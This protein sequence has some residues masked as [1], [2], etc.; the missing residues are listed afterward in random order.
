MKRQISRI[1]IRQ[2]AKVIGAVYAV[3]AS[4]ILLLG[5]IRLL[6]GSTPSTSEV[7]PKWLLLSPFIYGLCAYILAF[8]TCLSYNF[9]ARYFGG[10]E[11]STTEKAVGE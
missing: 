2:T 4:P 5:I 6:A 11:Y 8:M 3:L 7:S 10:V 9:V 1:S